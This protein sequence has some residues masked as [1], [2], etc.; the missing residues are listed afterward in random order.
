MQEGHI[1]LKDDMKFATRKHRVP[2]GLEELEVP[3][4]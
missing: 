1:A 3:C 2:Y 4:M